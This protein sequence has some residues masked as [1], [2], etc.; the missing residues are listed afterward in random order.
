M[1]G[2]GALCFGP[3]NS[4]RFGLSLGLDLIGPENEKKCNFDCLYCELPKGEKTDKPTNLPSIQELIAALKEKLLQN[5]ECNVITLCGNG[6]PTLH[7]ELKE[8]ILEV[9]KVSSMPILIL[10]NGST[11]CDEKVRN[12]LM[13]CDIVKLSLDSARNNSLIKVDRPIKGFD[14]EKIIGCMASFKKEFR[15]ELVIEV[16]IVKDVNDSEEEIYPLK[17]ALLKIAPNKIHLGTIARAPAYAV[18]A[19]SNE[20]LA[21]IAEKLK[22]LSV[23]LA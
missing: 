7:P 16:L 18:K 21:N 14:V 17:D 6:E 8:I 4:R 22:P 5:P 13:L 15:G 19:V 10:S 12:A 11:I 1:G 23:T 9:R 3:I 2:Y 20:V